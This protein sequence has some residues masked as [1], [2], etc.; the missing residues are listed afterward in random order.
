MKAKS[1]CFNRLACTNLEFLRKLLS[2]SENY[3][4]RNYMLSNATLLIFS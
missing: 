1:S 4:S 2:V 3:N